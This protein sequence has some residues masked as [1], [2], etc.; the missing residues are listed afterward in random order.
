MLDPRYKSMCL[1]KT[2]VGCDNV[3]VLVVEY[4]QELLLL[5]LMEV[6]K[7]SMPIITKEFDAFGSRTKNEDFFCTIYTTANILRDLV[8]R[9]LYTYYW[10]HVDGDSSIVPWHG[11]A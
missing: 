11:S 9:E 8:S 3:I 5:L 1:V 2:Y 7:L 4:D 6:Y 10:Y